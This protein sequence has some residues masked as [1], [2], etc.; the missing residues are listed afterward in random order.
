MTGPRPGPP[1]RRP[2]PH[3]PTPARPAA[4]E[5]SGT[6]TG[7]PVAPPERRPRIGPAFRVAAGPLG[8]AITTDGSR[9]HGRLTYQLQT[10]S[11]PLILL[12]RVAFADQ[13]GGLDQHARTAVL[14]WAAEQRLGQDPVLIEHVWARREQAIA[15]LTATEGVQSRRVLVTPMWRLAMGIGNRANP[16]EV[17][18]SLHGTYGWPV[19]PGSAVKG[20]TAAWAREEG[21]EDADPPRLLRIFGQL[22]DV[23]EG[24]RETGKPAPP[25]RGA[26]RHHRGS[27]CFLDGLPYAR[28]VS[29]RRDVV[30]PHAQ[31]YYRERYR[32]PP[33][34]Y[35]QP[36]PAEFLTVDGGVF[37]IDLIGPDPDVGLAARWCAEAVDALGLGGKTAAGYGYLN[38]E[39]PVSLS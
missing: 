29:I 37:A 23:V 20:A 34:E 28:A 31:P 19:L 30:T 25:R 27:V 13:H 3:P 9:L 6:R 11:N 8:A 39:Q 24:E 4:Q 14:R 33:A 32:Q 22:V 2:Q 21:G 35:H 36:I 16:Y 26:E 18:L 12:R 10:G 5:P 17:G 7:R 1:P 15:A 38:A